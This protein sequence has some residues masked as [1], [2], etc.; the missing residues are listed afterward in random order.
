[1]PYS[2]AEAA[3]VTSLNGSTV[4]VIADLRQDRDA[5]R[6]QAQRLALTSQKPDPQPGKPPVSVPDQAVR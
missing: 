4:S 3:Q 1:M 2:L 6:D 5:W